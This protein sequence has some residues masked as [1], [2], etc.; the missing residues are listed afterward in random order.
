LTALERQ[1]IRGTDLSA[2]VSAADF[3]ASVG[4]YRRPLRNV[5]AWE[6]IHNLSQRG[7]MDIK[8]PQLDSRQQFGR[9]AA[10]YAVSQ[11]HRSGESL[12]VL[13]EFVALDG[14]RF[15]LAVDVA[16]G[17]GFT[18]F[19]VAPYAGHVVAT[20]L[21][22]EM[23]VQSRRLR[24]DRGII[25]VGLALVASESLPFAPDSLELVT[26]RTAAHHFLGFHE[27]LAEVKRVLRPGGLL[28]VCDT[29]APE[30]EGLARWMNDVEAR[31]DPSHVLN[32]SPSRWRREVEQ[33]GLRVTHSALC[34]SWHEFDD[35]T[36][37][38]GMTGEE[39]ERLRADFIGTGPSHRQAFNL[40]IDADGTIRWSWDSVVLRAE[41]DAE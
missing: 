28:V 21:T 7:A 20:D 37:R 2:A 38:S 5:L 8:E 10:A 29:A 41:K 17:T 6:R 39:R 23:L 26:C 32:L 40:S 30:D 36:T 25:N 3:Q 27:W 16:T 31:R 24:E 33:A 13:R 14:R 11:S 34:H 18:A 15:H 1:G 19:A 22:P 9:H 4:E 35:W 12:E